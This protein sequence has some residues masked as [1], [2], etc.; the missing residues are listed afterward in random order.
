MVT[1]IH[2][3][4]QANNVAEYLAQWMGLWRLSSHFV[5]EP[6]VVLTLLLSSWKHSIS[7]LPPSPKASTLFNTSYSLHA[8]VLTES[9]QKLTHSQDLLHFTFQYWAP[10]VFF[11]YPYSNHRQHPE[12]GC[13]KI[14]PLWPPSAGTLACW[15]FTQLT[16]LSPC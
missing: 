6:T 2:S 9:P 1:K 15:P 12:Q 3:T 8:N 14:W 13:N 7:W 11:L 16:S 4:S 10:S 5:G